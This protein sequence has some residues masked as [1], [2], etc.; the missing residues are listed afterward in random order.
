MNKRLVPRCVRRTSKRVQKLFKKMS[1]ATI[2]RLE[3]YIEAVPKIELHVHIEGTLEPVQMFRIGGRNQ[4]PL[5]GTPETHREIRK[6]EALDKLCSE[7]CNV[8]RE[9]QDFYELMYAYLKRAAIDNVYAAEIYFD[10]YL[11]TRRGVSIQTVLQGFHEAIV[12]GYNHFSIRGALIMH[13]THAFPMNEVLKTLEEV[14]SHIVGVGVDNNYPSAAYSSIHKKVKELGGLK[15]VTHFTTSEVRSGCSRG[16]PE[17]AVNGLHLCCTEEEEP[18]HTSAETPLNI[19]PLTAHSSAALKK[20]LEREA[21]VTASSPYP[22]FTGHYLTSALLEA[23]RLASLTE[24]DVHHLCCN[25]LKSSFLVL[26]EREHYTQHMQHTNIAMGCAVPPKSVTVF[27]SRATQPGTPDYQRAEEVGRLLSSRG[28]RIVTGGYFGIMEATSKGAVEAGNGASCRDGGNS[29]GIALGI[30]SPRIYPDA[31]LFGNEY[32]SHN[33][34]ARNLLDRFWMYLR[35]SEYFIAFGGTIGTITEI[36][37]IWSVASAR[38]SHRGVPQKIILWKPHWESAIETLSKAI[39]ISKLDTSL[40]VYV[41]SVQEA[42]DL[43]EQDLLTR[44]ASATL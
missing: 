21:D 16:R 27:G 32:N 9:K 34:I 29:A 30:L 25:A 38:V 37:V 43:I 26:Q 39:G 40:L 3:A 15:I 20:H 36:L 44:A 8:L 17:H 42:V 28:Y 22:A 41:D 4:V 31:P 1:F 14:H 24:K 2:S 19:Q 23:S 12:D 7:A 5:E 35:D 11:H 18:S 13:V 6:K 10:P 33:V